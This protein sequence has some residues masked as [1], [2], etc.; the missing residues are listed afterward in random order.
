MNKPLSFATQSVQL[1]GWSAER[2]LNYYSRVFP[3]GSAAGQVMARQHAGLAAWVDL[4]AGTGL[5]SSPVR[6]ALELGGDFYAFA[7]GILW[8]V[9]SDGTS[10]SVVFPVDPVDPVT[11][12]DDAGATMATDGINIALV[13][14][15]VY[16]VITPTGG[17]S[18]TASFPDL[19][20][21]ITEAT[22]VTFLNYK[23]IV[24]GKAGTGRADIIA[25]S[26][27]LDPT[28]FQTAAFGSAEAD[29]DGLKQVLTVGD[30][31]YALGNKTIEPMR[32][33]ASGDWPI[34]PYGGGIIPHGILSKRAVAHDGDTL[35]FV[36]SEGR[37]FRARGFQSQEISHPGVTKALEDVNNARCFMMFDGE[38]TFFVV[39]IPSKPAWCFG[40]STQRWSER[41]SGTDFQAFNA[42]CSERFTLAG[43]SYAQT[44]IGGQDGVLYRLD[45]EVYADG[46]EVLRRWAVS[47]PIMQREFSVDL[48]QPWM[49]TGTADIGRD[50][51]VTLYRSKNGQEFTVVGQRSLGAIGDHDREV[52]WNGLGHFTRRAQFALEVTDPVR[53]DIYGVDMDAG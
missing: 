7:G 22:S 46:D 6:C 36:S 38:E 40:L 42:R 20:G 17:F 24:S 37:V 29:P 13:A 52:Y 27:E 45:P 41:S 49:S 39:R 34:A 3:Q 16:A 32:D 51:K 48:I 18:A 2:M 43:T 8:R 31:L 44:I 9:K 50:P 19:P 14:S 1:G 11:L 10:N 15:G 25:V 12:S 33:T 4:F 35:Y 28:T 47:Q 26:D 30:T 21:G 23:M 5:A 53:A